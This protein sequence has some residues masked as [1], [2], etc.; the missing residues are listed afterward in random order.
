MLWALIALA[1]V[2]ASEAMLRLPLIAQARAV[3]SVSRRSM[4]VLSARSISDH[5]K[6]RVLPA[7]ALRMA[8]GSVGFF[9]SLCLALLPVVLI[10]LVAPGGLS[11]W[12]E[13]L[14]R[15]LSILV[16]CLVSLGYIWLRVKLLR[17]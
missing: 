11:A 14:L 16:L 13:T 15:P 8:K 7:Y 10:G 5:W 1:A 9:L 3:I 12:F 17:V 4:H 2:A 6:E